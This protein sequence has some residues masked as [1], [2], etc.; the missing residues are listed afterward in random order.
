MK[1]NLN[2]QLLDFDGRPASGD[3]RTLGQLIAHLLITADLDDEPDILKF[4]NWAKN[5]HEGH[6]ID[7]DSGDQKKFKDFIIKHKQPSVLVKNK[8]I[9]IMDAK[10]K[11]QK[12]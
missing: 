4:Y 6:A 8:I 12:K 7:L 10:P 11:Q 1:I 3:G 5:L 2:F 9:E